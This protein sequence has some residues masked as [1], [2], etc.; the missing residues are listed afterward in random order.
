MGCDGLLERV[1][2]I[3]PSQKPDDDAL[4]TLCEQANLKICR[5]QTLELVR[6]MFCNAEKVANFLVSHEELFRRDPRLLCNADETQLNAL[7][8]FKMLCD[9]GQLPLVTALE[10]IP[11]LTGVVSISGSGAVL[12]PTIVLKNLQY[13]REFTTYESHCR[14]ATSANG[15]ITKDV[16]VYFA[17]L[18]CAQIGLYR[19]TLPEDNREQD[20]LLVIEGH[21][22]RRKD[23]AAIIFELNGI[24]ALVLPAHSTHL[25]QMVD[26]AVASPIRAVFKQELDKQVGEVWQNLM[27]KSVN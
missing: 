2:E 25:L 8:R 16:W 20:K 10:H 24:D 14:F 5:P 18:F 26:V 17:L 15:W 12:P 6:R 7:K 23:R 27:R 13:L 9:Q 1:P 21:K 4:H 11:H 3:Y 19:L 22:T